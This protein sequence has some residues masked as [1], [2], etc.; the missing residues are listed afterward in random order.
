MPVERMLGY[1]KN[2]VHQKKYPEGS[3]AEGYIVDECLNSCC[4]YFSGNLET[5]FN[6]DGRNQDNKRIVGPDEFQVF[7]DGAKG[8]GK[9]SLKCFDK[10]VDTMVWYVLDNC[11]ET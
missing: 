9:S 8:L 5:R 3:I 7:S 11:E 10:D 4:R 2:T 6:K 1:L